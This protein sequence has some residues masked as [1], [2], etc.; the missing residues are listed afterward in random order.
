MKVLVINAGSSSCKYQLLEMD[1]QT[2]LCYGLVERIGQ[3]V[4]CL[5][6][7]IPK[8]GDEEKI[9]REHAFP[10]HVEGMNE[11]IQ[12]LTDAH[13]GVIKDK[14]DIAAIGHRVVHGGEDVSAPVL[15]DAGIKNIIRD[16]FSLCP[17]HNP[18]NLMGIEVAEK[19]FPCAPN[20]AVF[21]TEFGMG[22]PEEAY[23]Y[24]LPY[25]LYENFKV[26]R[27]GFH[28]TSH[29]YIAHTTA[30][31]LKKP[32]NELRSITMHLGN[33]SSMTCVKNG[34]CLDTS[35]GLTP[36]EGLVM[37]TRCGSIDPAIVPFIMEKKGLS[38]AE[39][40]TLMNK[41]SGLLG[42]CDYTDMR[43]VHSQIAAG[44]K[45][46]E[47]AFKLLVRSIKKILGSYV[48]L[49]GGK[50]DAMVF[51]AGIGENDNIT[52]AAVC[53]GLEELGIKIDAKENNTRKPGARAISMPGSK[54]PVLI[55]PTNEELQIAL[56]A[57]EVLGKKK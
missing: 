28:G 55:I 12:L 16:Q 52:R 57:L 2:V 25:D 54:I 33:G 42:I 3:P 19:L 32:L 7:R 53:D 14:S 6:H 24:A 18:A 45:R 50:V 21:D 26:R 29:K 1:T 9:V 17:L 56:A 34:K 46:A 13:V 30:A 35:M 31:W 37:G 10:T 36:L 39:A 43:D 48:F 15:V 41:Q 5:T 27:Y 4:G 11:V 22:M 47:L 38:P 40:D 20:V 51:T 44:N 23:M 49:L 8:G